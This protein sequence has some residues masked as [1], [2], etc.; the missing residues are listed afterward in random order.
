MKPIAEVESFYVVHLSTRRMVIGHTLVATGTLDTI[1]VHPREVFRP[2]V[3]AA[4][5]A[6]LL[7]HNLCAQAHKLCY[8][9]RQVM[10]SAQLTALSLLRLSQRKECC[11]FA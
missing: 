10:C 7:L 6:I 3:V 9:T 11:G 8:V 5:A 2:A 1:L 4:S